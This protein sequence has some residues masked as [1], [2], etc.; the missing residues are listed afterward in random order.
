MYYGVNYSIKKNFLFL[1]PN[2]MVY[3][4]GIFVKIRN[5]ET[6]D[7]RQISSKSGMGFG[8]IDIDP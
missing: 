8:C 3:I 5:N 6:G 7:V 4:S 1:S 2:I